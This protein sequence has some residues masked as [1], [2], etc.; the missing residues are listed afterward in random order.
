ME[1]KGYPAATKRLSEKFND[2]PA[3]D[4][5]EQEMYKMKKQ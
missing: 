5:L 2:K 1:I 3:D 4:L